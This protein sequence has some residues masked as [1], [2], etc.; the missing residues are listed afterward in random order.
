MSFEKHLLIKASTSMLW[1]ADMFPGPA[2]VPWQ[3]WHLP[4]TY[5]SSN[6]LPLD[7]ISLLLLGTYDHLPT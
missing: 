1:G 6:T 7:T 5:M 3:L 4:V 2:T